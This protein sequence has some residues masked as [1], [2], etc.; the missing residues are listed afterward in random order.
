[1]L[2]HATIA[3]E[4]NFIFISHCFWL[5]N[6]NEEH[7]LLLYFLLLS[8]MNISIYGCVIVLG[9]HLSFQFNNE[10]I[11]LTAMLEYVVTEK[12]RMIPKLLFSPFFLSVSSQNSDSIDAEQIRSLHDVHIIVLEHVKRS[13]EKKIKK[14]KTVDCNVF[15]C[16]HRS[17]TTNE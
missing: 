1:M 2:S 12:W 11:E 15:S 6:L 7:A 4:P 5:E 9:T 13:T 3:G 16:S 17:H 10:N 14:I 8:I